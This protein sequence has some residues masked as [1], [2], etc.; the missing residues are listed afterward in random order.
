[1]SNGALGMDDPDRG[2]AEAEA[3]GPSRL[4]GCRTQTSTSTQPTTT[5]PTI[6]IATASTSYSTATPILP[7]ISSFEHGY[8]MEATPSLSTTTD[9]EDSPRSSTSVSI[10]RERSTASPIDQDELSGKRQ[11]PAYSSTAT[12]EQDLGLLSLL[13]YWGA[14]LFAALTRLGLPFPA[15]PGP[16]SPPPP[17][18]KTEGEKRKEQNRA[19]QRAFRERK[20][21]HVREVSLP[22][23]LLCVSTAKREGCEAR[24]PF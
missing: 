23:P 9:P 15:V 19:A 14:F 22:C 12:G 11:K 8:P 5:D 20:E 18:A 6:H 3:A 21:K 17:P 4:S 1:M 24:S 16:T 10:K 2:L 13:H 7:P